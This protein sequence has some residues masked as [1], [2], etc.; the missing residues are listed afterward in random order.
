MYL[1][2]NPVLHVAHIAVI[3]SSLLMCFFEGL[4]VIHIWLQLSIL[5]SWLIVGPLFK[6]PGMC[7]I[8]E[9]QRALNKMHNVDFPSSYMTYL[10]SSMDIEITDER[11]V[12]IITFSVFGVCTAI[13]LLRL[14]QNI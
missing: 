6:K 4:I 14:W 13:S 11:K 12:D 1:I 7:V 9:L 2:F 10:Y 3:L 8:T 5:G